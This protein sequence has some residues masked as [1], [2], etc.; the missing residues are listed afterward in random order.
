M[1]V[2]GEAGVQLRS[3]CNHSDKRCG[4]LDQGGNC[5][6]EEKQYDLTILLWKISNL[7]KAE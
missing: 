7:N 2:S 6:G 1:E 3:Y 4:S 5:E